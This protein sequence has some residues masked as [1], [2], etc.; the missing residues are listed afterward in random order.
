MGAVPESGK[1][2]RDRN[3]QAF[4][5]ALYLRACEG[6]ELDGAGRLVRGSVSNTTE[7]IRDLAQGLGEEMTYSQAGS[8]FGKLRG[9]KLER[10]GKGQPQQLVFLIDPEALR[11]KSK[12]RK[13]DAPPAPTGNKVVGDSTLYRFLFC[14]RGTPRAAPIRSVKDPVTLLFNKKFSR[15][16]ELLQRAL[17]RMVENKWA[18]WREERFFLIANPDVVAPKPRQDDKKKDGEEPSTVVVCRLG[19][20]LTQVEDLVWRYFVIGPDESVYT[21]SVVVE[22]TRLESEMVSA[23]LSRLFVVGLIIRGPQSDG[24]QRT[25]KAMDVE[26][27]VMKD[28]PRRTVIVSRNRQKQLME[29]RTL[30]NELKAADGSISLGALLTAA[31][32][33]LRFGS[34]QAVKLAFFGCRSE[35]GSDKYLGLFVPSTSD[36]TRVYLADPAL[37]GVDFLPGE[38]DTRSSLVTSDDERFPRVHAQIVRPYYELAGL[39]PPVIPEIVVKPKP[40][41]RPPRVRPEVETVP[42][43]QAAI[44]A[45]S[46]V[47]APV[48]ELTAPP[49]APPRVTKSRPEVATKPVSDEERERLLRAEV[50][51]LRRKADA[52]EAEADVL[53]AP[54]RQEEA[55]VAYL[56]AL[57]AQVDGWI[58]EAERGTFVRY[59]DQRI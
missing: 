21:T 55:R 12:E 29:L 18:K 59:I 44:N 6:A 13:S 16:R 54:R 14:E 31:K 8:M 53:A 23:A 15:D 28:G 39:E 24:W 17:D 38:S 7:W 35:G 3:D 2:W 51:E 11:P 42:A 47:A 43:A 25:R 4:K 9:I 27:V 36:P 22:K 1:P 52:L 32:E 20:Y 50:A 5:N 57:L 10:G 49:A 48:A 41:A 26:S 45:S 37:S 40:V 46:D 30:A 19:V 58:V 34:V 56:K 33:R